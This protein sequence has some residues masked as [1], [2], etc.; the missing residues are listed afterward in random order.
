MSR[1][2][3]KEDDAGD[4]LPEKP[5]PAGPNYVTPRGLELLKKAGEEL[6]KRKKAAKEGDDLRPIDRDLR[7]LEARLH[8]ALVIPSGAGQ[9]IRF[10]AKVTLESES[11]EQQ[12]FEIVGE[13]EARTDSCFL[14]WSSPLASVLFGAKAGENVFLETIEGIKKFRVVSVTYEKS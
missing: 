10:G 3:T 8:S 11:G 13:D 6:L 5:I 1:A 12:N 14:T 2:F 7:Y 9:E 4:D